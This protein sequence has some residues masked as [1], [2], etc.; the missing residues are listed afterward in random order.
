MTP[1]QE[2]RLDALFVRYWDN[3]LTPEEAAELAAL[4]ATDPQ[5]R[6]VFHQYCVQIL[7]VAELPAL[8]SVAAEGVPDPVPAPVAP[9]S[10]PDLPPARRWTRRQL[11]GWLGGGVAVAVGVGVVGRHFWGDAPTTTVQLQT[12]RGT[13]TVQ[14]ARGRTVAPTAPLPAGAMVSTHGVGSSVVLT[15]Q[16][17]TSIT[18][19]GDSTVTIPDDHHV[20]VHQGAVSAAV[21]PQVAQTEALV[22]FTH[23]VMLAGLSGVLVTLGE[24]ARATEVEVHQGLVSAR[25]P[26]GEPIAVVRQGEVLT[27]GADGNH[28]KQPTSPTPEEFALNLTESLPSGWLVGRHEH[29]SEGPVIR[30]ERWPDPYWQHQEMYQIRSNQPW[31]RG[32]FR[33]RPDSVVRVRYRVHTAGRGQ[34]CFCVR[35][36]SSACPDTGM[37]EWNGIYGESGTGRWDW[38]TVTADQMRNPP[39]RHV[40]KFADPWIGFLIIFNTYEVDLGLEVAEFRVSRPGGVRLD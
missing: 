2:R 28:R 9:L 12:V 25:H 6:D 13:V 10:A 32:F 24:A 38:L 17:G 4:L 21:P 34:L 33:L 29:T 27:V 20:H 40:P 39:N 5:S 37:L 8:A 16:D 3:V 26:T 23:Q 14:D 31:T 15:Y 18:L 19:T 30:T 22:M 11:L 7:T 35:T 36:A 1:S